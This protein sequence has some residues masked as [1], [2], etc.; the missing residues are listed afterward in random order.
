MTRLDDAR[1]EVDAEIRDRESIFAVRVEVVAE[2]H[3]AARAERK[4]IDVGG[5]IARRRRRLVIVRAGHLR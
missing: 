3:A 2:L 4:S 5:L 1:V